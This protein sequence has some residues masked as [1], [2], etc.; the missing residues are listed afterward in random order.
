MKIKNWTK[1][2]KDGN[3]NVP[4]ELDKLVNNIGM[5][6]NF[7]T[8]S[9]KDKVQTICDIA[10]LAQKFFNNQEQKVKTSTSDVCHCI[11]WH[12]S[13]KANVGKRDRCSYCGKLR[14]KNKS[15]YAL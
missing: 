10:Y 7:M 14:Q 8:I 3:I 5:Q 13:V 4:D 6:I 15:K 9:G 2:D 12:P 1:A 11:N